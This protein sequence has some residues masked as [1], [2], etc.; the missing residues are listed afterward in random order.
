MAQ[1][2]LEDAGYIL[3]EDGVRVHKDKGTRLEFEFLTSGSNAGFDRWILP[4][5]QNLKKIGV[6]AKFRV[7]DAAQYINRIREY[8]FD[9]SVSSFGQS[10]SPGNEQRSYWSSQSAGAPGSRNV[11]GIKD[12]VVDE[13]VEIITSAQ[14]REELVIR[15]KALD[16]VLQ[17]GFYVI[18]NW[19]LPAWRVAYWNK[20][21]HPEIQAP[22][23]IG[24]IDT[25]WSKE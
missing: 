18:P 15:C 20:F 25:W 17:W 16:R 13:L 21:N 24:Y 19:H 22:Y 5:F 7:V 14:S 6:D 23:S 4:L 11:I 1:K 10:N 3:D 2:I 9:M 8:D 12:P